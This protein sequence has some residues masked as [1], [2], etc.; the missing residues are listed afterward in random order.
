[1]PLKAPE[2][3]DFRSV[4]MVKIMNVDKTYDLPKGVYFSRGDHGVDCA[5]RLFTARLRPD[6]GAALC[7]CTGFKV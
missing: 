6:N 7:R 5:G 3:K 4:L 2:H 1:M